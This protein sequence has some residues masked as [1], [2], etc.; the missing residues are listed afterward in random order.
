MQ[1]LFP[2]TEIVYDATSFEKRF[3]RVDAVFESAS[4]SI[5]FNIFKEQ[6]FSISSQ[7]S[8][9]I[10]LSITRFGSLLLIL[11]LCLVRN[12][13]LNHILLRFQLIEQDAVF[14]VC[15]AA[16]LKYLLSTCCF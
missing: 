4:A 10:N 9:T 8:T 5:P 6:S 13:T 1:H 12:L 3:G 16:E 11:V 15:R 14:A 2:V 7:P